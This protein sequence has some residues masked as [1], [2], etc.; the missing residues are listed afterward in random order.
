MLLCPC[1]HPCTYTS[2][3]CTDRRSGHGI[4]LVSGVMAM[5]N[6]IKSEV[7]CPCLCFLPLQGSPVS[8]YLRDSNR[9]QLC[10]HRLLSNVW[11]V[12]VLAVLSVCCCNLYAHVGPRDMNFERNTCGWVCVCVGKKNIEKCFEQGRKGVYRRHSQR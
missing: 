12:H 7:P 11:S 1:V 9:P 8:L 6:A 3:L 2:P 10:T 5:R 4:V